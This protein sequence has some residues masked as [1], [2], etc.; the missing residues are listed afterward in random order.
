MSTKSEGHYGAGYLTHERWL[1][2]VTQVSTV[3]DIQPKTVVEVGIGPGVV[4]RMIEATFPGC[5]YM[6]VDID[7]ELSPNICASVTSLPFPD[8]HFD[9]VFCCQV[10]E[11]LPY[12]LFVPA[13]LE[14]RRVAARRVVISL[15]DES[16]FFF[17]RARGFRKLL[18]T[19]WRGVSFPRP[20][21]VRHDFV[22]HGQH[23]W[24]IGKRGFPIAKILGDILRTGLVLKEN[25]RMVERPYWHFFVLDQP[26]LQKAK[27]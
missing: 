17:L 25:F 6:S 5:E 11:H 16:L 26:L 24:E 12:D 13:I 22:S 3:M 9:A 2:Y 20:F 15:P 4:G 18:P 19:L 10:L 23:H 21:P 14:L 1:S 7:S 27:E 8:A